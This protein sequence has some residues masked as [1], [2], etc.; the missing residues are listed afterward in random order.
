LTNLLDQDRTFLITHAETILT[1]EQLSTFRRQVVRRAGGEPLQYITGTQ[2]FFGLSFEV[3]PD[4]LIPRPESELLVETALELIGDSRTG[5]LISDIGTGT[6]CIPIAFLHER[7]L[8]RAIAVD[9]SWSAIRLAARNA[10]RHSVSERISFLVA[11]S[12][13]AFERGPHFDLVVSNPPYI[14]DPHWEIL[15]R[16]VR[17][18]EPRVALTSGTDGLT[19]IRR[20]LVETP[21]ILVNGGYFIFEMGYDQGAIVEQ[22]IDERVW[23]VISIRA[24]LQGIPRTAVLRKR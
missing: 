14:A 17:D 9:I 1:A 23:K 13:S 15:Q 7:P 22:L 18:H 2:E 3:N 20:L 16:E 24:D 12:L 21:Q 19:M 11:D 6:G 8:A 5:A 4:A 10:A